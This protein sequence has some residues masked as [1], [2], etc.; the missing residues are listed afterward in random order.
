MA[1][2]LGTC[3]WLRPAE[4]SISDMRS[5]FQRSLHCTEMR[6]GIVSSGTVDFI[7]C[8]ESALI[9]ATGV[10]PDNCQRKCVVI[11]CYAR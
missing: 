6:F 8:Y 4:S 1:T 9:I 5:F 10:M 7:D 3:C 2:R 11:S